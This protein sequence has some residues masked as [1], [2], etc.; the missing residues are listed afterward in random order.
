MLVTPV[1]QH[2]G[3]QGHQHLNTTLSRSPSQSDG[4]H[5]NEMTMGQVALD[6]TLTGQLFI[7]KKSP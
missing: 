3:Y 7:T 2:T 1:E 4:L 6:D 5:I